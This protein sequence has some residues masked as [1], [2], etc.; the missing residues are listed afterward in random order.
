MNR[1]NVILEADEEVACPRCQ[2]HFSLQDG[3]SRQAIDHHAQE[4]ERSLAA[5]VKLRV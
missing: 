1:K 4:F 3:I 5:Q 2:H